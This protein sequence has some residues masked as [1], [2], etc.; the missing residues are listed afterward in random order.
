[1]Y[2]PSSADP[3]IPNMLSDFKRT[4]ASNANFPQ[5]INGGFN[6]IRTE[7]AIAGADMANIQS[8]AWSASTL[9][10]RETTLSRQRRPTPELYADILQ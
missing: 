2:T 1:M 3:T 5:E 9:V 8:P 10:A 6:G 4:L 7:K